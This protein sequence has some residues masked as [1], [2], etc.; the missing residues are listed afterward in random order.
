MWFHIDPAA[1]VPVYLQIVNQVKH[2]VASGLLA[3]GEQLPS[4][5]EVAAQLTINP[6]TAAKAYQE[7]EQ[8]KV[9][10][11]IKGRGTFVAHGIGSKLVKEERE[12]VLT[13]LLDQLMVEAIHLDLS[14]GDVERLFR[15]GVAKWFKDKPQPGRA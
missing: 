2:A 1:G 13:R 7:L 8:E 15:E 10:E 9:I 11:T 3:P 5:R 4:I 12:R 6:N 14:A